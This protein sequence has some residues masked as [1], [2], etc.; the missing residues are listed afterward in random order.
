VLDSGLKLAG[1]IDPLS[2]GEWVRSSRFLGDR[3]FVVT[4]KSIDPFFA[5][6][7]SDAAHPRKAGVLEL[8]GFST[9]LQPIDS[10]HLLA[11]G[12]DLPATAVNW[13]DRSLQLSVF[14]VSDLSAPKR[15]VQA[16]IASAYA[17]SEA[18]WEHHAFNWFADKSL[19]SVP[20]FDWEPG[21]ATN[22]GTFTSDLRVFEVHPDSIASRGALSMSDL[23][24]TAGN[25]RW[26]WTWSPAIRR[27]VM[28]ADASGKTFVYG[29]SDAGVRVA[30]LSALGTPLATA[31]F[32]FP[33]QW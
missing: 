11:I 24:I 6:D 23:Y 12:V 4:F 33:P 7:L 25:D 22:W 9:Y 3:G 8:P 17:Y 13:R 32:P 5:L 28:A 31:K 14:D 2:P 16:R 15:T 26:S 19:V 1:E 30:P 10:G 27:S 18:L 29:V 21:A 20:F